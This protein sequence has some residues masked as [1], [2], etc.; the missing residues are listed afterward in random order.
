MRKNFKKKVLK[1]GITVLF[2]KRDLPVV[3]VG[4]AFKYGSMYE[5]LNEKGIAHFIEHMMFKGTNKL[6]STQI[7]SLIEKNGGILNAFT[8]EN[9]TLYHFKIPSDKLQIGLDVFLDVLKNSLFNEK[10]LE[11]ERQVIFEEIKLHRDSPINHAFHEIQKC[12]YDGTLEVGTIGTNESVANLNR[13]KLVKRFEKAY[14][15]ENMMLCVVGDANFE[16]IVKFAEKNFEKRKNDISKKKFSKINKQKKEKRKGVEQANMIYAYH[17]PIVGKKNSYISKL[18]NTITAQGMSSRLFRE[19]REKRNLAYA[20]KGGNETNIDFAYNFI[21]VGTIKEKVNEVKKI[22]I[23]E[24]KDI[25]DNLKEK[26]LEEAKKQL[27]GNYKI[28]LEESE[29]EMVNLLLEEL[30][31]DASDFYDFEKNINAVKLKDVKEL[32]KKASEK[33]SFY[34]LEPD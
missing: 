6:D 14:T 34:V 30:N 22:I 18:L 5:S 11:K 15:S 19:I 26:E 29:D 12:L 28:S 21:Y 9:I 16:D 7:S 13:D 8:S 33:F 23:N 20:I 17:V 4:F 24:F 2:E 32:A 3:S 31:G 1:N 27:I 25:A 10:E